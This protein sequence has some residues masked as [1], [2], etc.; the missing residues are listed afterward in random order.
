MKKLKNQSKLNEAF[1]LAAG[2][3]VIGGMSA[4]AQ[5]VIFNDPLVALGI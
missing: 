3:I 2:L 5:T 1:A 4:G